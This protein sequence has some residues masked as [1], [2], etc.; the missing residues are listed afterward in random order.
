[1]IKEE[2]QRLRE[3]ALAAVNATRAR[4]DVHRTALADPWTLQ[5]S[6]SFR[7]IGT[8][9]GDGDVLCA[10]IH[11]VDRHPDLLAAPG[12]LDYVIAAQPSVVLGLLDYVDVIEQRL[13]RLDE[14]E[15]QLI[16]MR[17]VVE[18]VLKEVFR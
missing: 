6:N 10:T 2:R 1:M 9:H 16:K 14:I 8:L 12:V 18:Q 13:A 5:T 11:P 15:P 4:A 17:A 7:R 3:A